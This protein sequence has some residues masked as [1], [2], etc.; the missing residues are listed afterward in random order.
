MAGEERLKQLE[1]WKERK[2]LEKEKEKRERERKGV[3]KTGMDHPKDTLIAASLPV[4]PAA[5]TRAKE[6]GE[7]S[8][9]FTKFTVNIYPICSYWI[10]N[11]CLS[12]RQK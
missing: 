9:K 8:A 7:G 10:C 1:R 4:V 2:A 6:V 3:F 12:F 11:F 5:S